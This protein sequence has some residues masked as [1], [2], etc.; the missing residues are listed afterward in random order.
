MH[1]L[2]LIFTIIFLLT[3]NIAY[4]TDSLFAPPVYYPTNC[5]S[6]S[7]LTSM[8]ASDLDGDGDNDLVMASRGASVLINNGDGTFQ[9]PVTYVS[10]SGSTSITSVDLDKD[11]DNDLIYIYNGVYVMKNNGEG[12]FQ[13]PDK[14]DAGY[15]PNTVI[16]AD[17]DNDGDN[18]LAVSI[19]T[20]SV[21]KSGRGRILIL[22]NNGDGTFFQATEYFGNGSAHSMTAGDFDNDKN[23]D[24]A[25][26]NA[27]ANDVYILFNNSDGT[28]PQR[29]KLNYIEIGRSPQ[30]IIS[31]DY[32]NDKD[33]DLFVAVGFDKYI[34]IIKNKGNG[35]FAPLDKI[36][37]IKTPWSICMNDFDGDSFDDLVVSFRDQIS[38]LKNKRD[39]TFEAWIDYKMAN[40]TSLFSADFDGD[41]NNDLAVTTAVKDSV[42]IYIN[43]IN[44]D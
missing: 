7:Q 9:H 21:T 42:A 35:D 20:S 15:I 27:H 25:V 44:S 6:S 3:I 36:D 11:N 5:K 4:S 1:K 39:G 30:N 8:C 34:G 17:F 33:P 23:I 19:E 28:F 32:D 22:N 10:T 14:Y 16:A 26:V 13:P 43:M 41:G 31:T 29:D 18:D 24:L 37:L 40:P 38:I 12:T 2:V